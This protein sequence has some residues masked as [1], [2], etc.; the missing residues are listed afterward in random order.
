MTDT[1]PEPLKLD[2]GTWYCYQSREY[3]A[4]DSEY[5]ERRSV[6][7][8]EEVIP[9]FNTGMGSILPT[10]DDVTRLAEWLSR[11]IAWRDGK[12]DR[13]DSQPVRDI[14]A[15]CDDAELAAWAGWIKMNRIVG[16][17]SDTDRTFGC[18]GRIHVFPLNYRPIFAPR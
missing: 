10:Q 9:D 7:F 6:D 1:M 3:I 14:L 8:R 13:R 15:A 5:V 11:A 17:E 12:P 2:S 4:P 18:D 16:V